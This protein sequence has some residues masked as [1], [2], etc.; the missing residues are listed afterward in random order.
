MMY[1]FNGSQGDVDEIEEVVVS[2]P[3]LEAKQEGD[4]GGCEAV[5]ADVVLY[6]FHFAGESQVDLEHL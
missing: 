2:Y 1:F 4:V 5:V 3:F 6:L